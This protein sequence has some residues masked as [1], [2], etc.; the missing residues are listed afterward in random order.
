METELVALELGPL[1]PSCEVLKLGVRKETNCTGAY[2][3]D[4]Q[5]TLL[6]VSPAAR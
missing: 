1:S 4:R 3:G 6:L 5:L 2:V